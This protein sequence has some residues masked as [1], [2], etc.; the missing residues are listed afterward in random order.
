MKLNELI[1]ARTGLNTAVGVVFAIVTG[2]LLLGYLSSLLRSGGEGPVLD[3][4]VAGADIETG[5]VIGAEMIST[6][7]VTRKYLV[8]GTVR[9]R[10]GITGARALRFIGKGEPFT[11]SSLAG[12]NG[13]GT[14]SARIPANSR[15]YSLQLSRGSGAGPLRPG[16]RLDV[17]AT[18]GDPPKTATL[19]RERL[20][21]DV[22]GARSAGEVSE[23]AQAA[24]NV[25]L[26]VSPQEAEMLAQAES[27]GEIAVS[28]CPI[29]PAAGQR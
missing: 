23:A 26:L 16:D 9:L 17:L 11:S 12:P 7:K 18:T 2:L 19:L 3:I 1:K 28:L 27:V 15:A 22:T 20:V 5:A 29:A 6:G 25:T 24:L 4:P 14:L 13:E 10:E 21:L 8:P